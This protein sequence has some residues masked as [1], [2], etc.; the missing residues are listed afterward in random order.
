L[1]EKLVSGVSVVLADG[2]VTVSVDNEDQWNLW[3]LYRSLIANM[4]V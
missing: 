2:Q 4:V 1:S 3:G